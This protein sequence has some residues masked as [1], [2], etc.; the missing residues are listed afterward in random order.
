MSKKKRQQ[1][2]KGK[3]YTTAYLLDCYYIKSHYRLMA[4]DLIR[5]KELM[6]VQKQ[7]NFVGQLKTL[8]SNGDHTDVGN[9]QSM[10]V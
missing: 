1:Q 3:D 7:F 10:F 6:L 5:Q 9:K 4:V 8:N 2:V